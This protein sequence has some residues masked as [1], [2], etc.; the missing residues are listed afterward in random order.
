ME[1]IIKNF[2]KQIAIIV[3]IISVIL[4]QVLSS[5]QG[6][7]LLGL[8]AVVVILMKSLKIK[9]IYIICAIYITGHLCSEYLRP[10]LIA[11]PE[12]VEW[13]V[14][15]SRFSLLGFIIPLLVLEIFRRPK[16]SYIKV[17]S[18]TRDVQFPF[19]WVGLFR[20]PIWRFLIIFSGIIVLSFSF[21]I[22]FTHQG[23]WTLFA[24]AVIF[25]LI[26]SILEEL[27]WRG[28]ILSRF[29]DEYGEKIGLVITSVGFGFYHL[30]LGFSLYMCVL[31][32]IAGMLMGGVTIKSEGLLPVIIMHFLM[33]VMF[34]LV[35]MIF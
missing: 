28:Y 33:N 25:S 19:I 20:D 10:I 2:D 6:L 21:F 13:K 8:I 24:Y 26:N 9:E 27:M 32:S 4:I 22:D 35:G 29:V 34:V 1:Q 7:L 11:I 17:G 5:Y 23:F 14:I 31:F 18:F 16:I 30:S 3:F 15:I 12:A